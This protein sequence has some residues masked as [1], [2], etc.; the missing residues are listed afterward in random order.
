MRT[1][2]IAYLLVA[3]LSL[4]IGCADD[5]L[6]VP[7]DAAAN[8]SDGVV[9]QPDLSAA[10]DLSQA[11]DLAVAADLASPRDLTAPVDAGLVFCSLPDQPVACTRDA[12]CAMFGGRCDAGMKS[13][14]CIVK[15]CTP[16]VDQSCNDN[17]IFASFHGRCTAFGAC[18]CKPMYMKSPATGKCL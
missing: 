13:C 9:A 3:A 7:A 14:V 17:P 2:R 6:V 1:L 4:A 18:E 10:P 11:P 8:P 16:G 5:P 12:E 15:S